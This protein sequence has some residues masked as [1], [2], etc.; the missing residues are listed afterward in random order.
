MTKKNTGTKTPKKSKQ[1]SSVG[2]IYK[3]TDGNLGGDKSNKKPR[4]VI[5]IEQRKSDGAI[6]VTKIHKKEGKDPKDRSR[7][8]Q[9]VELDPRKHPSLKEPSIV[10]KRAIFGRKDETG[11]KPIHERDLDDTGD[12]LK[13]K[14]LRKVR[15]GIQNDDPKH[16]KTYNKTKRRWKKGFKK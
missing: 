8:I 2:K 16:R 12:K 9:D 4:K 1:K 10:E 13:G 3:T 15:K 6:A 14:E 11:Y 5:A 7:Y